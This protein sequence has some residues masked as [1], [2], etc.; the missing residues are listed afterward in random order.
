M[1]YF[2]AKVT[3]MSVL[4]L[5]TAQSVRPQQLMTKENTQMEYYEDF[6]RCDS[7]ELNSDIRLLVAENKGYHNRMETTLQNIP[8]RADELHPELKDPAALLKDCEETRSSCR[9]TETSLCDA[10]KVTKLKEC[11]IGNSPEELKQQLRILQKQ[12]QELL[13][14]N[15]K[16]DEQYKLMKQHYSLK[17]MEM[18]ERLTVCD[19]FITEVNAEQ[20]KKQKDFDKKLV[21]AKE[22]IEKEQEK[23]TKLSAELCEIK[24]QSL[25]L[26]EQNATLTKRKDHQE[27]EI[28]R[29]NKILLEG[30]G[31]PA[32]NIFGEE[33][34]T[35]IE[36][37]RHQAQIYENDFKEERRDRERLKERNE[38]LEKRCKK[39]QSELQILKSQR[40][41]GQTEKKSTGKNTAQQVKQFPLSTAKQWYPP[42]YCCS[43]WAAFPPHGTVCALP[44]C[45]NP[46]NLCHLQD[47]HGDRQ[48]HPPNYQWYVSASDQLP[49][50]V[51]QPRNLPNK[52][53]N[54][55][56][57]K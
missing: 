15:K 37:L 48:Q 43:H 50:D 45:S 33:T 34:A 17:I 13:D 7:V 49:P 38:E 20:D 47:R 52:E 12:R 18:K 41:L 21:L 56:E 28:Q 4:Q 23:N 14:V 8:F 30:L 54:G 51:P 10:A 1:C 26:K 35:Q 42:P 31:N 6:Q 40:M 3:V 27:C 5:E 25:N 55:T 22:K 24:Q 16:W 36:V 44:H 39:L 46:S 53:A 29:L 11:L 57:R 19:K 2:P 9:M 32:R